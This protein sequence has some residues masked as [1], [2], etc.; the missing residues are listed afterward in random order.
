MSSLKRFTLLVLLSLFSPA[1]ASEEPERVVLDLEF[2]GLDGTEGEMRYNSFW[3]Y[4]YPGSHKSTFIDSLNL[5]GD[6][7]HTLYHPF[8]KGNEYS[9]VVTEGDRS[10]ALY[11]DLDANGKFTDNEKIPPIDKPATNRS[12]TEFVTPV[13]AFTTSDGRKVQY[14]LLLRDYMYGE[15]DHNFMWSPSCL[16]TSKATL[17]GEPVEVMLFDSN[18]NGSFQEFGTD[19]IALVDKNT[20]IH[21]SGYVPR[22]PLSRLVRHGDKFLRVAFTGSED[23]ETFRIELVE[24]R[25]PVGSLSLNVKADREVKTNLRNIR[26]VGTGEE[27]ILFEVKDIAVRIPQGPY[28]LESCD[29]Y[30]ETDDAE[31]WQVSLSEGP[32]IE[33]RS[34]KAVEVALGKPGLDVTVVEEAK[35]WSEEVAP[36]TEFSAGEALYIS[37]KLEGRSKETYGRFYR[38]NESASF[39]A[40]EPLLRIVDAKENVVVDESLPYG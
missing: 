14:R 21:S 33:V 35:R 7:V 25:T 22:D 32:E 40:M 18:F 10:V 39:E 27:K 24:D 19:S 28:R 15:G 36:T 2:R 3:G 20:E 12:T 37:R 38:R 8:V 4:G 30:Y 16:W 11:F 23:A 29:L 5:S 6:N 13:I 26:L 17:Q 9:A 34:T 31:K 1:Y